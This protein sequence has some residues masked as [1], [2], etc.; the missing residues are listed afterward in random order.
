M[1]KLY[2]SYFVRFIH[3]IKRDRILFEL[4]SPTKKDDALSKLSNFSTCFDK[5]DIIADLTH[6]DVEDAFSKINQITD[7]K[8][9]F[10]LVYEEVCDIETAYER[11]VCSC[12]FN[13]LII[14]EQTI[15]YVGEWC[16]PSEKYILKK[17]KK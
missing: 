6:L 15:V 14:D 7:K 5:N 12:M 11:A 1:K 10:D 17:V 8:S 3:K 9:C 16:G 4:N 2:L 13:A